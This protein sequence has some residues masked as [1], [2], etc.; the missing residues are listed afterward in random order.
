MPGSLHVV[1]TLLGRLLGLIGDVGVLEGAVTLSAAVLNGDA[2]CDARLKTAGNIARVLVLIV[3]GFGDVTAVELVL[4]DRLGVLL[5]LLGG[6][7][8]LEVGLVTAGDLSFGRHVG[9]CGGLV[10]GG[11]CCGCNCK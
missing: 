6:V 4:E 3:S 1:Q 2:D 7:G 8:V 10:V 5:G 11:G 9:W